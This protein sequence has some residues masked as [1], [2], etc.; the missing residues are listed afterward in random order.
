MTRFVII[1]ALSALVGCGKDD[2]DDTAAG[3]CDTGA[4]EEAEETGGETGEETGGETGSET[5][6]E[7]GGDETGGDGA[8]GGSCD[9][10]GAVCIET[11]AEDAEGWCANEDGGTYSTDPCADGYDGMCE[12]PGGQAAP[13]EAEATAYYYGM[14]GADACTAV[15]GTYTAADAGGDDDGAAEGGEED[16]GAAE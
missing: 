11:T 7:T 14:D 1:G 6:G 12:I 4:T 15:G 3:A 8:S 10:G 16:T 2:C 9:F 13:Y 5:G